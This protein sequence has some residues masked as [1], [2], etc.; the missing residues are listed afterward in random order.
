MQPR[1]SVVVPTWREVPSIA[2][3]F[4]EAFP[5][6]PAAALATRLQHRF[7][8]AHAD[9]GI[10]LAA[11]ELTSGKLIGMAIA[12]RREQLDRARRTFI[13]GN[14]IPLAFQALSPRGASL[15]AFRRVSGNHVPAPGTG[16]ELRYLAVTSDARGQ[17]IGSALLRTVEE[18]LLHEEP[19]YVWV[20]AARASAMKF[21]LRHGFREEYRIDG[22]V[23]L[24]K[25]CA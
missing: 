18:R 13:Y 10:A 22:H 20:L 1:F 23:R 2:R 11:S 25:A 14:A 6:H 5:S 9:E 17:G 21:Y 8:A 4:V 15:R 24:I 19:Y 3:L 12:G 16:H 7:I